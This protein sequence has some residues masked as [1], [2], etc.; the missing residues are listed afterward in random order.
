MK[1]SLKNVMGLFI[2]IFLD[3]IT[4]IITF[5]CFLIGLSSPGLG[6]F[7][8]AMFIWIP[9]VCAQIFLKR[10]KK[11]KKRLIIMPPYTKYALQL[12]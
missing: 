10:K 5:I 1:D 2:G 6:G 8:Y 7:L 9:W 4:G 11:G 3:V 12:K